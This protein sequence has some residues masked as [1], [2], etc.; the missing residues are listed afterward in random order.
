MNF[1]I[2]SGRFNKQCL[3]LPKIEIMSLK[4]TI[5]TQVKD[6]MKAKDQDRLRALRAIKSAILLAET[7]SGIDEDA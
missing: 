3:P 6:A 2:C 5:N 1:A 7:E 4:D